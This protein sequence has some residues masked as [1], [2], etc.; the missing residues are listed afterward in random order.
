MAHLPRP[1]V[2]QAVCKPLPA[3]TP[4]TPK[5]TVVLTD[6]TLIAFAGK[7]AITRAFPFMRVNI[8]VTS[9][10]SRCRRNEATAAQGEELER[11]RRTIAGLPAER[12][13][14][15]KELMGAGLVTFFIRSAR[16]PE[17][18]SF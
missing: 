11:I 8:R 1:Q 6:G 10:C 16:G 7:P 14:E 18:H 17:K 9:N 5:P 12:K 4:N 13:L 3:P 2:L 15:L